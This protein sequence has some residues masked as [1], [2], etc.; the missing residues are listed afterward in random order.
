[1]LRSAVLVLLRGYQRWIS[2]LSAPRCRFY[3]SC[4][5]Y[6]VEAISHRGVIMGSAYA[7]R[8]LLRCHPFTAGGYDP[9]PPPKEPT[10][11]RRGA[12]RPV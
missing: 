10:G 11:S 1:M 9:A 8:R 12:P 2:P 7:V 4:S 6:A 5:Q 3:P